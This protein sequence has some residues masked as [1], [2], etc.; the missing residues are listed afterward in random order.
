MQIDMSAAC[1]SLLLQATAVPF[2][3]S[4]TQNDIS[5]KA[6]IPAILVL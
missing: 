2:N 5:K 6:I 1:A 3:G 4:F